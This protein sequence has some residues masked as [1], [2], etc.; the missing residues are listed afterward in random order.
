MKQRQATDEMN[1]FCNA[2]QLLWWSSLIPWF[3][4]S[5]EPPFTMGRVQKL[6]F[7]LANLFK[8]DKRQLPSTRESHQEARSPSQIPAE[9]LLSGSQVLFGAQEKVVTWGLLHHLF[10]SEC[11]R[12]MVESN[13]SRGY[14]DT[15]V[16]LPA[17]SLRRSR[18]KQ[19]SVFS[20]FSP[21][22]N[23]F[24]PSLRDDVIQ[25]FSLP[26]SGELE[27]RVAIHVIPGATISWSKK[28]NHMN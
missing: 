14:L 23:N 19:Q 18:N 20:R 25:T 27:G 3:L 10:L 22:G 1:D 7:A 4:P 13:E 8:M 28:T 26:R 17:L 21:W 24:S 12:S 15:A 16:K 11:V 9:S 5:N 2:V 6:L